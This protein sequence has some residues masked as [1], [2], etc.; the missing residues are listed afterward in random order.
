MIVVHNW[1]KSLI[2]QQQ[3][4]HQLDPR[5]QEKQNIRP[6][7]IVHTIHDVQLHR[8]L[9]LKIVMFR[10][11]IMF[12]FENEKNVPEQLQEMQNQLIIHQAVPVKVMR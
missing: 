4:Q 10:I 12:L 9:H 1:N 8:M 11:I 5:N 2:H 6:E 3:Q 7:I